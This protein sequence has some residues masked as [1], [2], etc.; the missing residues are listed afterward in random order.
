MRIL[1]DREVNESTAYNAERAVGVRLKLFD[2]IVDIP[3]L[4]GLEG[5][6]L[7]AALLGRFGRLHSAFLGGTR[8]LELEFGGLGILHI[9]GVFIDILVLDV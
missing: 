2:R 8:G 3:A 9:A 4:T 5:R 1:E 7:L 6:F